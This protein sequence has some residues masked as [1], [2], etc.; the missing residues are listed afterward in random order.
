[1]QNPTMMSNYLA[2]QH[3]RYLQQQ[4]SGK[5]DSKGSAQQPQFFS[6]TKIYRPPSPAENKGHKSFPSYDIPHS[7]SLLENQNQP[8][9]QQPHTQSSVDWQNKLREVFS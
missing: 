8:P 4:Q 9:P 6:S 7:L 3:Q 5:D 2:K 1:M